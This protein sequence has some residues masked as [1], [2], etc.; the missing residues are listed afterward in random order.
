[1]TD[2]EQVSKQIKFDKNVNGEWT[3]HITMADGYAYSVSVLGN[4]RTAKPHA[5]EALLDRV[6]AQDKH[7]LP[8]K[9]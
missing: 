8:L 6:F 3:A 5:R 7:P 1:M 4:A 2:R 9:K